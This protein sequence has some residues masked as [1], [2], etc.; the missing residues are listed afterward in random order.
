MISFNITQED[1]YLCVENYL[2]FMVNSFKE[3]SLFF[4]VILRKKGL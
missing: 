3:F 2:F 4:T 1:I